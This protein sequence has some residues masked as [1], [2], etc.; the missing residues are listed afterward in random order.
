MQK[1]MLMVYG[2][3]LALLLDIGMASAEEKSESAAAAGFSNKDFITHSLGSEQVAGQ[4]LYVL[5]IIPRLGSETSKAT[6]YSRMRVWYDPQLKTYR[7]AS[8]WDAHGEP[9]STIYFQDLQAK[10]GRIIACRIEI[11]DHKLERSTVLQAEHQPGNSMMFQPEL[12]LPMSYKP[13]TK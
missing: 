1:Q 10:A 6:A 12:F 9:S 11:I 13:I 4:Q 3:F 2:L 7:R 8:F 5:E